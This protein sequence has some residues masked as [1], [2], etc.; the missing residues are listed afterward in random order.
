MT[1]T[2]SPGPGNRAS[3]A[4][5]KR[6][7]KK[8]RRL[9]RV[10]ILPTLLVVLTGGYSAYWYA[11][12]ATIKTKIAARAAEQTAQ[13]NPVSY[14]SVDVTGFPFRFVIDLHGLDLALPGKR[15]ISD[16]VQVIVRAWNFN[17]ILVELDGEQALK[18]DATNRSLQLNGD[19]LRLSLVLKDGA[20]ANISG[21]G[22]NMIIRTRIARQNLQTHTVQSLNFNLDRRT[23]PED[24]LADFDFA[25]QVKNILS[26]SKNTEATNRLF[27]TPAE[28]IAVSA[29]IYKVPI[30][31]Q[32][33]DLKTW[34]DNDGR[35]DITVI[36]IEHSRLGLTGDGALV[37]DRE[38]YPEGKLMLHFKTQQDVLN[39]LDEIGI[40]SK[41]I[42]DQVLATKQAKKILEK[43][44]IGKELIEKGKSALEGL[45]LG[46]LNDIE[47]SQQITNLPQEINLPKLDFSNVVLDIKKPGVYLGGIR[48]MKT[49][50]L[51]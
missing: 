8:Q 27:T 14:T 13:G 19:L 38:G 30:A 31:K 12:A 5:K 23:P 41:S 40:L 36:D 7:P 29:V 33:R 39:A 3:E 28:T 9:W 4:S 21:T 44:G 42:I 49:K 47:V 50:P 15:F 22:R 11:A 37:L 45:G 17:H 2:Q 6:I 20:P 34:A 26:D 25:L 48:L 51:F 35:I 10:L 18:M 46:F 16:R 24:G 1:E 43:A 32:N